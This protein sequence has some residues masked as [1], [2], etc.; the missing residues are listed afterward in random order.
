[1]DNDKLELQHFTRRPRDTL[2]TIT[3][4]WANG[5]G[6]ITISAQASMRWLGIFFDWKLSFRYH[7]EV[8]ANRALSTVNGLRMLANTVCGMSFL[9][10]QL[11]YKT[12]VL[13]VLTFRAAV[14]YTGCRQKTLVNILQHTQN[15]A[16]QHMAGAFCT[17]PVKALHH[18]TAILPIDLFLQH[19]INTAAVRLQ[20]LP[21]TSQPLLWLGAEWKPLPADLPVQS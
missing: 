15:V 16:L 1:M 9:N 7:V 21:Q 19:T 4:P 6:T 18:I 12:V 14:W 8:M 3:V 13:L 17:T 2:P 11:L 20:T 5:Q 10:M